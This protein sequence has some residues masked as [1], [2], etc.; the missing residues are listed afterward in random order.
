MIDE[1]KDRCIIRT[2]KK[3]KSQML[4]RGKKTRQRP[5]KKKKQRWHEKLDM[6]ASLLKHCSLCAILS[7]AGHCVDEGRRTISATQTSVFRFTAESFFV[8]DGA[9]FFVE[10]KTQKGGSAPCVGSL[11]TCQQ[12]KKKKEGEVRRTTLYERVH[13]L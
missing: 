12:K 11:V 3:K 10:R 1:V 7:K 5:K 2:T 4:K 8:V 13:V 9:L 6:G